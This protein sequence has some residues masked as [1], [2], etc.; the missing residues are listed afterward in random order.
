MV[1]EDDHFMCFV[2]YA[3]LSPFSLWI[4]P[5]GSTSAHFHR[6]S[7]EQLSSFARMLRYALQC[8]H[9]GLDEPDF[10]LVIR[11]AA[12]ETG[13]MSGASCCLRLYS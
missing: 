3:A 5:K 4:V 1:V 8:L 9:V 11:S 2:P 10:N 12:L 13:A 7:T 6:A